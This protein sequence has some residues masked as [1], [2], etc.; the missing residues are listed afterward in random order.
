MNRLLVQIFN[1]QL[2][3][4]HVDTAVPAY[5][6]RCIRRR[7]GVDVLL[8]TIVLKENR[9]VGFTLKEKNDKVYVSHIE[10]NSV[11]ESMCSRACLRAQ[12]LQTSCL[13]AI[14]WLT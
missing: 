1:T 9:R 10:E 2:D 3:N 6:A 11:A 14:D 5:R 4:S 12:L 7:R 8:V 13:P